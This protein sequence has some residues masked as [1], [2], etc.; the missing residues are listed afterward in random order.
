MASRSS[1]IIAV[2]ILL[3]SMFTSSAYGYV[4]SPYKPHAIKDAV[5]IKWVTKLKKEKL[6]TRKPYQFTS[7][8]V[9]GDVLY[10]GAASGYFYAV[11]AVRGGKI[12]SIKLKSGVYADAAVDGGY[13]YAADRKGIVYAIR[14]DTGAIE[15]QSDA[16][17]EIS[18]TPLIVGDTIIVATTLKQ[19]MAI[20]KNG[21]GKKWQTQ[22]IGSLP[23][24]TIKGASSPILYNGNIY[25]G[26]AD[27][28]FFCY[29]SADGGIVWTKLLSDRG[30]DFMDIDSAPIVKDGVLF[31]A[32]AEG[33]TIALNP[34]SGEEIWTASA[35]GA[36]DL[37][38][39]DNIIYSAGNSKL[40]ALEANS[41]I[42]VWEQKFDAPEISSPVV[43]DDCLILL[44]TTGKLYVVNKKTGEVQ[45]S[46]F[47][48][49][50][51]YGRPV[52]HENN[53]Y[54]LSNKSRLFCLK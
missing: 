28:M 50:G 22:K 21:G 10:I 47:L 25:V 54:V 20:D 48:G 2:T 37:V 32:T 12:W 46:R 19:V 14:K 49:K 40:A 23:P 16:G 36:N 53:I 41:G 39:D 7:P 8:V 34:S 15:W 6:I 5:R 3:F 27:G 29:S 44:S 4:S 35:G 51:S 38:M 30:A 26:Y 24:M 18:A 52:V 45:Y 43:R 33:K 17:A 31:V 11:D 1:K 42:V 9:D 13:V